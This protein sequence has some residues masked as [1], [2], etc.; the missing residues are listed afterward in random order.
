MGADVIKV[1]S[2][3]GDENRGWQPQLPNGSSSNYASVNRGKRAM[4]LDLKSAQGAGDPAP[5]DR[6]VG[7]A[8]AQFPA[9]HRRPARPD[10]RRRARDQ[11]APRLLHDQ[12]LWREGRAA[13]QAGLRPDGAGLLRHHVDDRLRGRPAG[14]LGRLLHR[15]GDRHR[16]LWRDRQRAVR[17]RAHGPGR[18]GARLAAGDRGLPAGLSRDLLAPGRQASGEAGLRQRELGALPGFPV[19]RRLPPDGRAQRRGVAAL[20]R[21]AG[22]PGARRGRALR[23][24]PAARR[25]PGRPDPDAGEAFPREHRRPLGRPARKQGRGGLAVAFA[26]S[27][28]HPSAGAG[29]RHADPCHR[30][31]RH[32]PAARRHALQDGGGGAGRCVRRS[33]RCPASA[34]IPTRSSATCWAIP[35]TRSARCAAPARSERSAAGRANLRAFGSR[36][37]VG[38]I[39]RLP[40][41]FPHIVTR[42]EPLGGNSPMRAGRGAAADG[43]TR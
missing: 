42:I 15:H 4:T 35:P 17:A 29:E 11:P 16:R 30:R 28:L 9:R 26:R 10:L 38:G 22:G 33:A 36:R 21:G 6:A 7:R 18:L 37:K 3:D 32:A 31:G 5:A 27:G 24:H 39:P 25:Q 34:R 41:R 13:Q 1:E 23:H 43:R 8:A 40:D 19:Q 20:L 2:P 12:R 14:A